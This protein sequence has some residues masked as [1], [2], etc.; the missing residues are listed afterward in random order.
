MADHDQHAQTNLAEVEVEELTTIHQPPMSEPL[1]VEEPGV[2]IPWTESTSISKPLEDETLGATDS[3]RPTAKP[4]RERR[5]EPRFPRAHLFVTLSHWAMV[6]LLGL[7]FVTGVRLTWGYLEAPFHSWSMPFASIAPKGTLLGINIIKL[8]VVL[9]FLMLG[10]AGI[11]TAYMFRSGASR[12][13][14]V[15]RQ[16]FHRLRQ[17]AF[18]HG[19]RWTKSSIWASNLLAYWVGFIFVFGLMLTGIALYRLDWGVSSWFGGYDMSRLLHALFAYLLLPY[20]VLH[21]VLQW[22]FGRFWSIFKAQMYAPHIR[23]GLNAVAVFLPIAVAFYV[24]NE[25]PIVLTAHR[26]PANMQAPTLDGD[27]G[28]PV[29]QYA[30]AV[31]VRTTKGVNN[32]ADHVDVKMQSLH[33]GHYIYFKF[34]WNDPEASYKRFPLVKTANGWRIL[35]TAK[36]WGDENVYYED[37]LS[38]Y[39]TDVTG[40]SCADTCHIGVGPHAARGQKH[41]LHYTDGVLGDVWHWKSVRTNYMHVAPNEPGYMDDQFFR[42]PDLPMPA[43]PKE[44]Y[45]AGY[46]VDPKTGGGYD[47][48]YAKLDKD[49]PDSEARVQPLFL[50]SRPLNLRP[51]PDPTTSEEQYQ[52]WLHKATSVPYSE[53]LD[54]YPVGTLLPNIVIEP[55]QGD[56]ANIRAKARWANGRWT[57]E[58]RRALDTKSEFDVAF[59]TERPVYLTLATYNRS[60]TRHSEHIKPV[61]LTLEK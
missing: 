16:T 20:V 26:V 36:K 61:Q 38:M 44:R 3:K 31:T 60:Q 54:T 4:K 9:A 35:E 41:G 45:T 47:Y 6:L 40:G 1:D 48:N 27:A 59:S 39:V 50:P 51:N 5:R 49:I 53:T 32:P 7:S 15:N 14:R 43:D 37:K 42:A 52:W 58:A 46:H 24:V 29:W 33:D 23:A 17:G 25:L 18:E 13:L 8:H 11:Y 10:V 19:W 57:L 55:F 22:C 12:R 56:R 34:E 30:D 21:M 2:Q 28:D